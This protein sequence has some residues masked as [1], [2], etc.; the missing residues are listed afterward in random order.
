MH[1]LVVLSSLFLLVPIPNW[2][3]DASFA[4]V[5]V[6]GST[7]Y[8]LWPSWLHLPASNQQT[9]QDEDFQPI[10]TVKGY[11]ILA[12]DDKNEHLET[13]TIFLK[14]NSALKKPNRVAR[15]P[16]SSNFGNYHKKFNGELSSLFCKL[17]LDSIRTSF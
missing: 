16:G 9:L 2:Q 1:L 3:M 12:V 4:S 6:R 17:L 13:L 14:N 11:F 5:Y 7:T 8:F 15:W 10:K